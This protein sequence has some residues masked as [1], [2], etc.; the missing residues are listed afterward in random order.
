[1]TVEGRLNQLKEKLSGLPFTKDNIVPLIKETIHN[2]TP[3]AM[4]QEVERSLP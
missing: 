2:W 3:K 1:M 4:E